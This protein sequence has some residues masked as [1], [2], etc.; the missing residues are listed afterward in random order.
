MRTEDSLLEAGGKFAPYEGSSRRKIIAPD[1][2]VWVER[3]SQNGNGW[4][5]GKSLLYV[6]IEE[7][8]DWVTW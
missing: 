4:W 2:S 1:G 7:E 6:P 5:A 8:Q 3:P